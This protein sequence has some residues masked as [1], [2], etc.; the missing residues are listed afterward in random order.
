M[1][2][3][4]R[5]WGIIMHMIRFTKS[6]LIVCFLSILF[7]ECTSNSDEKVLLFSYFIGNGEDGLHLAASTDGLN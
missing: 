5:D 3:R 2:E 1:D 4:H 6:L 7:L